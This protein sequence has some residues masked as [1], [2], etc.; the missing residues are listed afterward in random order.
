MLRVAKVLQRRLTGMVPWSGHHIKRVEGGTMLPWG[1]LAQDKI[2]DLVRPARKELLRPR[3]GAEEETEEDIHARS[4]YGHQLQSPEV[5]YLYNNMKADLEAGSK[6]AY[7]RIAH[8][9]SD[10]CDF[11][12]HDLT[13]PCLS[14]FMM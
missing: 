6:Q 12:L 5:G 1:F 4:L 14:N 2:S 9:W 11:I 13:S 3:E 8:L 7:L 10:G